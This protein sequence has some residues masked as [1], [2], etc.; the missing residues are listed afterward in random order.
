MF[1]HCNLKTFTWIMFGTTSTS[2]SPVFSHSA[3]SLHRQL[4]GPLG[5]NRDN[6]IRNLCFKKIIIKNIISFP[7]TVGIVVNFSEAGED[8]AMFG[9]VSAGL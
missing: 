1:P 8:Q 9:V 4:G 7:D 5:N 3:I 6:K 2:L